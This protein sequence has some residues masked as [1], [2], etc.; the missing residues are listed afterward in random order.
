MQLK[1]LHLVGF[2]TFADKTEIVLGE[3]VTAVVGPNGCGK[4][5]VGDALLW[6]MGEQNPRLLRGSESRDVIFSGTVRRKPLGM[7][8]VRLTIDNGDKTLPVDFAEV[9]VTRRI[10]RSGESQYLLN[11]APCRLKDIVEMFLDTGIGTGAYSFVSQ[12]EIDAVLSARA[13]DRR[14]LFE[15]AAGIKKYRVKK[16]EAVRKLEQAESNLTRIRDIVHELEQQRTPLEQQAEQ[17]RRYLKLTERLQQ[18]EVDLLIAEAQRADYEL[19]ANRQELKMD[20]DAIQRFDADLA[21][22]ERESNVVGERLAESEQELDIA[23]ISQQA[24]MTTVERTEGQLQLAQ[25]R[26]HGAEMTADSLDNELRE[27]AL[28]AEQVEKDI[29]VQMVVLA[30]TESRETACRE[31]LAS[32][33]ARLS[34]FEIALRAVMQ[35]SEDRQGAL[36]RLAEQRAQCEAALA[37]CQS[38]LAETEARIERNAAESG[39]LTAQLAAALSHVSEARAKLIGL[40][41]DLESL[42]GRQAGLVAVRREAQDSHARARTDVDAARRLQSERTSRLATLT[43]LQESGEG[44]YQGVR[45]VL[46]A[47]RQRKVSGSFAPV[48]DLLTVPE[49]I[50]IAVE[51]ALGASAQDIVCDTEAEAKAAIEWLKSTRSG[52][53]TF[54]ALPLLH[55]STPLSASAMNGLDGMLGVGGDLVMADAKYRS[56]VQLLLGRV[57]IA[58]DMDAAV[59][60]SL[61]M[62]GWSRIVT[63]EGE[64]LSPGGALTGGSLQGRG[65][66]LVGRKGE[67]DDLNRATPGLSA[68]VARLSHAVDDGA[69]RIASLEQE[70]ADVNRS[71]SEAQ[72]GAAGAE[73]DLHAAEQ[74]AS[75]LRAASSDSEAESSRVMEAR[76]TLSHEAEAWSRQVE[77]GRLADTSVDDAIAHA[78][79]ESRRLTVLRDDARSQTVSLEVETGRLSEKR[80]ALSREL[81]ANHDELNRIL[82]ARDL[83]QNQ[84]EMASMQFADSDS[85]QRELRG[86]LDQARE[87]LARCEEQ[88]TIWRDRRQALLAQSF[89]EQAAIKDLISRRAGTMKQMHDAELQIARL[90][91]RLAQASQR[92]QDEY[93]MTVEEAL[94]RTDVGEIDKETASEVA[95]LRREVRSMGAVNTGA[96]EEY[97]RLTERHDFLAEQRADLESARGSLLATITEID[98]STHGTFMETFNAVSEEFGRIFSRLFNGGTTQLVLTTPDDLLETGIDVFAQPPGK[99]PQRLTLLSGGERA[100]TATALLFSFLAV[101]PSPFVLLDEVDASLDGANVERFV[102][103]VKD[104]SDRTQF[105]IITHNPTT[106]E[107]APHWYGVTM[108][109]PGVSRILAYRVPQDQTIESD[110]EQAVM[111]SA[112]A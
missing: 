50:R 27:L 3:G 103:L 107:A 57:A 67:I 14:E 102:Q 11:N 15:E 65:A 28:R 71:L 35:Q 53:A 80:S 5:N 31:D 26:G 101:K 25:E 34:E 72:A 13:E 77:K 56:V 110:P 87:H 7:A 59:R 112:N 33:R 86:R 55:P 97:E 44:F 6:V 12:N 52:R 83:K 54:L 42:G 105:L 30:D 21:A 92:L 81:S 58:R 24:A 69:A 43:E 9:T 32:A 20:H 88:F 39:A 98:E 22:N 47:V 4:S 79:E 70:L 66:H 93:S 78:Q 111:L 49:E 45:A 82:A 60:A 84:R 75:R 41:N 63:M 40:R 37:G 104:F 10:Y 18:I 2:K 48:V 73:R 17:S 89:E 100:L 85:L 29:A 61:R 23:R 94:E 109:E 68:D 95:K 96:V 51:V 8:E 62:Q 38:R 19:Y 90:E 74:D 106:M 16:R 46:N 99:K 76:D 36:R 91:V 1:K 64:V 108:Q